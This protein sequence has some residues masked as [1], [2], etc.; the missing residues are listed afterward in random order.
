MSETMRI[1]AKVAEIQGER[2]IS[3]TSLLET[4]EELQKPYR[5]QSVGLFTGKQ[6]ADDIEQV[7]NFLITRAGSMKLTQR[8]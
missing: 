2:F 1:H 6:V 4:F 3:L 7:S 5:N 8:F